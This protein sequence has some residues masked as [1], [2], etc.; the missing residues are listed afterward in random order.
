MTEKLKNVKLKYITGKGTLK[1][2][3]SI[4]TPS[5]K[6]DNYQAHILLSKEEGEALVKKMK[7]LQKQQ[8]ELCGKK[9]KLA[10]LPCVPF[11]TQDE[12]TGEEIP[13]SEGRYILKTSR[14]GHN[15]KGET[16]PRPVVINAKKQLVTGR[17]NIGEGTTA[18]LMV[19]LT[20]YK[21]P[22]GIGISAKLLGCQIINLVEYSS[23][24]FSLD[25]FDEED[26]FD[27]LGEEFKV[28]DSTAC[29]ETEEEE[30]DF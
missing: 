6:Y 2:F 8:F 18:R 13:D 27:G 23:G 4:L 16:M 19:D 20:G 15:S 24:G 11:T 10:D 25:G 22:M 17:I 14:K 12:N 21:A 7:D 5:Q 3:I 30:E 29:V 1:G 28:E 9:G 26:G